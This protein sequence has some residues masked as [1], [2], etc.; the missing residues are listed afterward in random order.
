MYLTTADPNPSLEI[1]DDYIAWTVR[2]VSSINVSRLQRALW[3]TAT[4]SSLWASSQALWQLQVAKIRDLLK[5]KPDSD[6]NKPRLPPGYLNLPRLGQAKD[7][8][9]RKPASTAPK[10]NSSETS[11]PPSTTLP[12][13]SE[14]SRILWPLP[15]VPKPSTD[16]ATV[17]TVFKTNLAKN[18]QSDS[19]PAPRGTFTVSGLV[20]V[21][22]SKG[23]VMLD[24]RAAYHPMESRWVVIAMAVRRVQ[25]RKQ[26]PRG[27]R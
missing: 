18:W 17:S 6:P 19:G 9:A 10:V 14:R 3:P 7:Q 13:G 8:E 25:R 20:E 27:G 23:V 16:M 22:G 11:P 15:S 24:V 26:G 12:S 4:V 1:T 2:P 5:M 21:F